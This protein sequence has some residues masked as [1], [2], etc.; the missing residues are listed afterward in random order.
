[1]ARGL[2]WNANT[3]AKIA[4][5]RFGIQ[6]GHTTP[7]PPVWVPPTGAPPGTYDPS[8]DFQGEQAGLNFGYTGQDQT[9]DLGRNQQDYFTAVEQARQGHLAHLGALGEALA[10]ANQDYGTNTR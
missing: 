7:A 5:Q 2:P 6:P 8:L 1:M 4:Q 10:R 9:R 3:W